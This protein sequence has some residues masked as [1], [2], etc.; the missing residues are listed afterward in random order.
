MLLRIGGSNHLLVA[1]AVAVCF[2]FSVQASADEKSRVASVAPSALGAASLAP[3]AAK[4]PAGSS[5]ATSSPKSLVVPVNTTPAAPSAAATP[6]AKPKPSGPK[7]VARINLSNQK[8]YVSIGG[9]TK[10]A[11]PISSGTQ[12]FLTPTGSFRP[13]FLSKDHKSSLYD[14]APMPYSVFFNGNVATHGTNSVS[15]LGQPASHGCV[16]LRIG[17]AKTFYN[18]VESH[19][20]SNVRISVVGT[21]PK[22]GAA[23]ASTPSEPQLDA[24]VP[25]QAYAPQTYSQGRSRWMRDAFNFH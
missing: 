10:Y 20:L 3:A 9:R 1:V 2:G 7:I 25:P 8:M 22:N 16:R 21:T 14:D 12:G 24:T 5:A 19:G 4:L 11:W 23:I 13:Q 18:L 6:A 17:D 15:K